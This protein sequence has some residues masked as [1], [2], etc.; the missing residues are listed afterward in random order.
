MGDFLTVGGHLSPKFGRFALKGTFQQT[1]AI[2]LTIRP[3]TVRRIHAIKFSSRHPVA[4]TLSAG[5]ASAIARWGLC[6]EVDL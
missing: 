3:M 4:V 2:T 5:F 1:K 6:R